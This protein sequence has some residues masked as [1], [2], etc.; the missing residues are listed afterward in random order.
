MKSIFLLHTKRVCFFGFYE[1]L[2]VPSFDGNS[3]LWLEPEGV[4]FEKQTKKRIK[5]VTT[6][7]STFE[8]KKLSNIILP[9]RMK[10]IHLL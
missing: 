5:Y 1:K 4:S 7:P 3:Y 8:H 2:V 10:F 9:T 6:Q